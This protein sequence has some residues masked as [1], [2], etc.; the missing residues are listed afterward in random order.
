MR[1]RKN[2]ERKKGS[3]Q[4]PKVADLDIGLVGISGYFLIGLPALV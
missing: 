4:V 1:M 3:N 2:E